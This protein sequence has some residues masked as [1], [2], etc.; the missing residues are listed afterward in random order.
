MCTERT[1]GQDDPA[2]AP[3]AVDLDL[4]SPR[5]A[6]SALSLLSVV[7]LLSTAMSV[8]TNKAIAVLAGAEGVALMGLY[9]GLGAFILGAATCGS[10]LLVLQRISVARTE[11]E[12]SEVIATAGLLV[13]LQ[14]LFVFS[15]AT[16]LPG[17]LARWLLGSEAS[18]GQALEIQVVL[19]M[20]FFNIVLQ[21]V[22]AI[23]KGQPNVKPVA[24]LQ[25]ATAM[26]SLLAIFPLLRLGRIGL[27]VNVGSGSVAGVFLG[28]FFILAIYRPRVA[29]VKLS[30]SWATLVGAGTSSLWL[31]FQSFA[32]MGGMLILQSMVNRHYG[33][34]ALGHYTAALLVVDTAV[35]VIMSS[36][37]SHVLPTLGRLENPAAKASFFSRMFVVQ[38]AANALAA[39]TLVLGARFVLRMLF[40]GALAEGAD[41]LAVLG[42][43]LI[44]QS[45]IWS[46]NTLLLHKGDVRTFV[47]LDVVW[48]TLLLAGAAAAVW[49][50]LPPVWVAWVYTVSSLVSGMLYVCAVRLRYRGEF[51][52]AGLVGRAVF[53]L[54]LVLTSYGASRVGG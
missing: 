32:L 50:S 31:I 11:A 4:T 34:T 20:A 33:L 7:T 29:H 30:E 38:L 46:C 13:V 27:A 53:G 35:M 26:A 25:L 24:I 39:I 5:R 54:I 2:P 10:N 3:D 12:R 49:L 45:L 17:S 43:S 23:L 15:V 51:I 16:T 1:M 6:F 19:G 28:L 48:M 18:G 42:V 40:S 47:I 21:T 41:F 44:G 9:R 8:A 36:V 22:T 52:S 14:G 37:R